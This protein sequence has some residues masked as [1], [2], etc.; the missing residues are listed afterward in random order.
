MSRE[1]TSRASRGQADSSAKR[2]RPRVVVARLNRS[3][4]SVRGRNISLLAARQPAG[5]NRSLVFYSVL[6]ELRKDDPQT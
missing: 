1:R 5:I 4:L 6:I 3:R 2:P